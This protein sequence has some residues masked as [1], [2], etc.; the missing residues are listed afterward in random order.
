MTNFVNIK[1]R[2]PRRVIFYYS[3]LFL[4]SVITSLTVDIKFALTYAFFI[5]VFIQ[6][7]DFNCC[8]IVGDNNLIRIKYLTLKPNKTIFKTNE[9]QISLTEGKHNYYF[10][11]KPI[12]FYWQGD[13][14]EV[15]KR[16]LNIDAI[17]KIKISPATADYGLLK[18]LINNT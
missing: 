5:F 1:T 14:L 3:F 12:H 7:I 10:S 4:F 13:H 17:D 16:N 9:T 8:V 18:N 6:L 11:V 15:L 2:I